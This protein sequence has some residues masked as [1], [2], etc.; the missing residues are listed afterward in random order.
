MFRCSFCE[1]SF[2]TTRSRNRHER[3]SHSTTPSDHHQC[4]ICFSF[5]ANR[6]DVLQRHEKTCKG[7]PSK[8]GRK[9]KAAL[10]PQLPAKKRCCESATQTD[11]IV[12]PP[13]TTRKRRV[14]DSEIYVSFEKRPFR[15]PLIPNYCYDCRRSFASSQ[16]LE[17]HRQKFHVPCRCMKCI[18]NG[19]PSPEF[20]NRVRL[21][22]HWGHQHGFACSKCRKTFSTE[23]ECLR[24]GRDVHDDPL[25]VQRG[26]A[27]QLVSVVARER[28]RSEGLTDPVMYPGFPHEELRDTLG[29][30]T[31]SP[32]QQR[33]LERLYRENWWS[34][35]SHFQRGPR[36]LTTTYNFR[37]FDHSPHMLWKLTQMVLSDQQKSFKIAV[38]YGFILVH[39]VDGTLRYFQARYN[40]FDIL[41]SLDESGVD[42]PPLEIYRDTDLTAVKEAIDRL[43]LPGWVEAHRPDS[44]YWVANRQTQSESVFNFVVFF[45]FFFTGLPY[46]K[47]SRKLGRFPFFF[48]SV[49]F[50]V[51]VK[52]L[53]V[54]P[55]VSG[56][57]VHRAFC[58]YFLRIERVV[59]LR[60]FLWWTQ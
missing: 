4:S 19:V 59:E 30:V 17:T 51:S 18:F 20:P 10:L 37:T 36:E 33:E 1:S 40:N 49:F 12:L 8:K 31:S 5:T 46:G 28:C 13:P 25:P 58:A 24:H 50:S 38:K 60:R 48:F 34:I 29:V 2:Q 16:T 39:K 42:G 7:E 47:P 57:F 52:V 56:V 45:F 9:R 23:R 6:K 26:G 22:E 27:D 53:P 55:L 32:Q 54:T 35:S 11:P 43:N 14:S 44:N 3:E 41:S 15:E 21:E